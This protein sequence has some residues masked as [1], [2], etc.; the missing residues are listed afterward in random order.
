MIEADIVSGHLTEARVGPPIPIMGHPPATTGD[1]SLEQFLDTVLQRNANKGLKLDFKSLEVFQASE[2]ILEQF[3][4]KG[5]V[6]QH[7]FRQLCW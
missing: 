3:L 5:E 7:W 4:S 6:M 2:N 1:L